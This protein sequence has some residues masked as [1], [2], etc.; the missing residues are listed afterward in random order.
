MY[1]LYILVIIVKL[2]FNT[3]SKSAYLKDQLATNCDAIS[4]KLCIFNLLVYNNY[5]LNKILQNLYVFF[6]G[7]IHCLFGPS[8]EYHFWIRLLAFICIRI[9]TKRIFIAF[10][11]CSVFILRTTE[12]SSS[13]IFSSLIRPQASDLLRSGIW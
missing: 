7:L 1:C 8:I 5:N 12:I 6:L 10:L 3:K 9:W 13:P 4:F 2:I 11:R